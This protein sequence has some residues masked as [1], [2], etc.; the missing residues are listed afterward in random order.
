MKKRVLAL[1]L[2][3]L[4]TLSLLPVSAFAAD[5]DSADL[6]RVLADAVTEGEYTDTTAESDKSYEYTIVGSDGSQQTVTVTAA[7]DTGDNT[8]D[9]TETIYGK[10]VAATVEAGDT[11]YKLVKTGMAGIAA[12]GTYLIVDVKDGEGYALTKTAGVTAVTITD[13]K[14]MDEATNAEFTLVS[15][16]NGYNLRD[17]SNR[18]LY[19]YGTS[20]TTNAYSSYY[21]ISVVGN[22]SVVIYS[23]YTTTDW[24]GNQTTIKYYLTYSNGSYGAGTTYN[25]SF[26]LFEKAEV[27]TGTT[28]E[29]EWTDAAKELLDKC[30]S[31]DKDNY[32]AESWADF[33][34][35]LKAANEA[36]ENEWFTEDTAKEALDAME[37]LATAKDSLERSADTYCP[38]ISWTRTKEYNYLTQNAGALKTGLTF[39]EEGDDK[40]YPTVF[41]NWSDVSNLT[42]DDTMTVWDYGEDTQYADPADGVNRNIKAATWVHRDSSGATPDWSCIASVR[43]F[44]GT[45]NWP[46]GYD[47]DDTAALVSV[48]DSYYQP[49]YDYV[50]NSKNQDYI[51]ATKGK[52]I[53]P[54][55]DDIY[56]FM[57]ADGTELNA[58]NFMKYLVFW[59][60]TSGKGVWTSY[61]NRNADWGKTIPSTFNNIYAN[62]SFRWVTPNLWSTTASNTAATNLSTALA[63][64]GWSNSLLNQSDGWYTFADTA[65][66][67]NV[68][69]KNYPDGI[70]AN[71][72]MHIDIYCFDNDSDGGMDQ[73]KL[74]MV[75]TPETHTKVEVRYY[76]DTVDDTGYLG[77]SF[78]QNVEVNTKI[79][80]QNGTDSNQLNY[81]KATAIAKAGNKTVTDGRQLGSVPYTVIPYKDNVIN[82]LYTTGDSEYGTATYTYDFGVKNVYSNVFTADKENLG[83][84]KSITVPRSFGNRVTV[85]KDANTITYTPK[86]VN[87]S[88]TVSLTLTFERHGT[89]LT[90][91]ITFLPESNVMY[92]ENMLTRGDGSDWEVYDDTAN[93]DSVTPTADKLVK[94]HDDAYGY[95]EAYAD[96][97]KFSGGSALKAKLNPGEFTDAA[98]FTFTGTGFDLIS[99]CGTDTGMLLVGVKDASGKAVKVYVVDTYFCGDKDEDGNDGYVSGEGIL[100]YQV[101]VV[102]NLALDYG[103]YT[104]TVKG[105]QARNSSTATSAVATQS[106][107]NAVPSVDEIFRAAGMSEYLDADV[108]VSFMDDN[109]VLNGGTGP[110]VT[111]TTPSFFSRVRSFFRGLA[112]TQAATAESSSEIYAYIDAFRVYQPL[113]T[114]DDANANYDVEGEKNTKYYSLYDFVKNSVNDLGDYDDNAFVYIEHDGKVGVG[115]DSIANYKQKGPQNEVYLTPGSAIA[116]ALSSDDENF[117]WENA[118]FQLSAKCIG[119]DAGLLSIDDNDPI[120]FS[121]TT[122]EMYYKF[123][124]V[125][126]ADLGCHYV[127]IRNEGD[128]ILSLSALKLPDG[129]KAWASTKFAENLVAKLNAHAVED[130]FVPKQLTAKSLDSLKYGRNTTISI[131]SSTE[132]GITVFV[133]MD[134]E[135]PVQVKATNTKAVAAGK[136]DTFNYSYAVKSKTIGVGPHT[137][138]IYAEQNGVKSAPVTVTVEV[139]AK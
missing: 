58:D 119:T 40:T 35:A 47:L 122:T 24:Y 95:T 128:G 139:T 20:I 45:F 102:R 131:K 70:A 132:E 49:I 27:P 36:Y 31:E 87:I 94:V 13:G 51:D 121:G 137:F 7:D 42:T 107:S 104:V 106:A 33:E 23:T 37:A 50:A 78:M 64:T 129:V 91:D 67:A 100:D 55:N 10:V 109:S 65:G 22:V 11:Y 3:V 136:A 12:G 75:R 1:L 30:N 111:V 138:Q 89:T 127:V 54:A 69:N 44:A 18:Y 114:G 29:I 130:A 82:V 63:S 79:T 41:W 134:N 105:Y 84:I 96:D 66:I 125:E 57:Y 46:E 21:P 59:T 76:L 135:A 120:A 112:S 53:L 74:K 73:L 117:D 15:N 6:G 61:D 85:N 86:T 56:V 28:N 72:E 17:S 2:S 77:N 34:E 4:M 98:T 101:P 93:D 71:T 97:T 126:D 19:P 43:K 25:H 108:E 115:I 133:K 39:T 16:G 123:K 99:E 110:A 103:K 90:K 116:F 32:T 14:I 81:M 8:G 5:L 52:Y 80:L 113:G 62:R 88:E 92:E 48:N 83:A 38:T 60:G 9:N 68:L 26:Y 124:P 118:T